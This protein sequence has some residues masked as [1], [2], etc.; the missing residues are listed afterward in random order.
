MKFRT[1]SLVENLTRRLG[2]R[3]ST[4]WSALRPT[5]VHQRHWPREFAFLLPLVAM[6]P[7]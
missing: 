7:R 6:P 2:E 1:P 3:G 4:G 5:G